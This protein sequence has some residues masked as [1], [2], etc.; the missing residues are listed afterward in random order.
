[1][2]MI[3]ADAARSVDEAAE[4][5]PQ[6]D[7]PL[8]L[9]SSIAHEIR[10]P[11]A[12]LTASAEMLRSADA[13][14]QL[15]FSEIIERQALRLSSIVEGLLEAYRAPR[16]EV[17][18]VREMVHVADLLADVRTEHE[19][20]FPRHTFVTRS[21]GRK[22]SLADRRLLSIII[23]NLVSNAAK[24]SPSESTVRIECDIAGG[25][26]VFRISD[27]GPGVP[28]FL[29]RKIFRAGERGLFGG[30]TGCGL[31]LFIAQRLC[32]AIGAEIE[33]QDNDNGRGSCFA[34]SFTG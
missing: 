14:T 8:A 23:G 21:S 2:S 4:A 20:L 34:V 27:E 9:L 5:L 26:T 6:H 17:R 30:D 11:L 32:E 15:R 31:G 19:R 12:A 22:T 7:D 16:G 29:R 1:M 25:R 3:L 10:A 28:D 18:R 24:Y 33:V 13:E